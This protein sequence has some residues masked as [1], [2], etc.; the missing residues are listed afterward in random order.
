MA[1]RHIDELADLYALGSLS[2]HESAQVEHHIARCASCARR[3]GEAEETLLALEGQYELA[4]PPDAPDFRLQ[5]TEPRSVPW[6]RFAGSIA[7]GIAIG[8]GLMYGPARQNGESQRAIDSMIHSHFSHAQFTAVSSG[9][10]SAKVIYAHDRQ[11]LYVILSG[12]EGYEVDAVQGSSRSTLGS[13][14]ADGS[15]STLFVDRPVSAEEI[16]LVDNGHVVERAAL[17]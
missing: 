6:W 9:A 11:W 13:L 4:Q 2:E 14:R 12:R 1:E 8:V 5:L 17:R 15:V 7:A 3:V 16:D 10:P